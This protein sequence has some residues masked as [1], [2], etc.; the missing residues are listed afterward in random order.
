MST[1]DIVV[2]CCFSPFILQEF[3]EVLI[4]LANTVFNEVPELSLVEKIRKFLKEFCI[5]NTCKDRADSFRAKLRAPKVSAVIQ[6][7]RDDLR[8]CY[9]VYSKLNMGNDA[10]S[11]NET[12]NV[13]E[14]TKMLEDAKLIGKAVDYKSIQRVS[15]S[16]SF[17]QP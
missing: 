15:P 10:F 5:P 11:K 16:T 7:F 17:S 3:V 2:R 14:F 1:N 8:R 13:K 12:L 6:E 4:R 9:V